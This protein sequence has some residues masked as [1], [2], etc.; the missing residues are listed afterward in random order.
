V[1][2]FEPEPNAPSTKAQWSASS[3]AVEEVG[4]QADD[5][6]ESA[7]VNELL[8]DRGLGIAA[9]EHTV[10]QDTG[11]LARPSITRRLKR[12]EASLLR[13]LRMRSRWLL[14]LRGK[15]M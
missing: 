8:A 5:A 6:L 3:R 7:G 11:G 4:G 13:R 2:A 15:P 12:P 14:G 1:K 9:E 10:R